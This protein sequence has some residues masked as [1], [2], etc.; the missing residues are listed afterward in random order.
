MNTI[1]GLPLHVFVEF[2][3]DENCARRA[4]NEPTILNAD[5]FAAMLKHHSAKELAAA[6][7]KEADSE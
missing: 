3:N 2:W 7:V 1:A 5:N 6:Q 4:N